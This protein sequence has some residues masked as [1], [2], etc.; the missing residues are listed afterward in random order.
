[1]K[2]WF[3]SHPTI[4]NMC[5][6]N[7]RASLFTPTLTIDTLGSRDCVN[8]ADNSCL[9]TFLAHSVDVT[10]LDLIDR[11]PSSMRHFARAR[12]RRDAVDSTASWTCMRLK[13]HELLLTSKYPM[14]AFTWLQ[15]RFLMFGCCRRRCRAA[16]PGW[17]SFRW[18]STSSGRSNI[19]VGR[20]LCS[21]G[22]N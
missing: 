5:L 1:M 2:Y 6:E 16:F 10:S 13:L 9:R 8:L 22:R 21:C 18:N 12:K 3:F 15:V 11:R 19:G 20:T 17:P 4:I 14:R 7:R